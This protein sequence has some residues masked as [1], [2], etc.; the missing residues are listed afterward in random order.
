MFPNRTISIFFCFFNVFL[1]I[2]S[3]VLSM[4]IT[5]Y[6]SVFA[7]AV[8]FIFCLLTIED[9]GMLHTLFPICSLLFISAMTMFF[10][11]LNSFISLC[12]NY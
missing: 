11:E 3:I 9:T 5:P 4:N 8:S 12:Q 6:L 2:L 1:L 7:L 10:I